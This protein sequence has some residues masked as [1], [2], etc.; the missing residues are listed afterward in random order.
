MQTPLLNCVYNANIPFPLKIEISAEHEDFPYSSVGKES[1]CNVEDL[2][3][4]PGL[5][6]SPRKRNSNPTPVFLPGESHG[7]RSLAGYIQPMGS[8]SV[9]HDLATKPSPPSVQNK[10][11]QMIWGDTGPHLVVVL[12]LNT[13]L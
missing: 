11:S 7:Q 4:I 2:G 5:G 12:R 13:S 10:L 8:Q 9:R 1:A 6:R 3:S